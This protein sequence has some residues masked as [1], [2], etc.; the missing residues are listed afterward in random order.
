MTNSDVPLSLTLPYRNPPIY[1][2]STF[3]QFF[4]P[5]LGFTWQLSSSL[6]TKHGC[7]AIGPSVI[8]SGDRAARRA[9]PQ[10][11]MQE[12]TQSTKADCAVCSLASEKERERVRERNQNRGCL[13]FFT[14][15]QPTETTYMLQLI[16][17]IQEVRTNTHTLIHSHKWNLLRACRMS[18]CHLNLLRRKNICPFIC[19]VFTFL[20]WGKYIYLYVVVVH[21]WREREFD[22]GLDIIAGGRQLAD[23][24]KYLSGLKWALRGEKPAPETNIWKKT[25]PCWTTLNVNPHKFCSR[26]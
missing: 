1:I 23:T 26:L 19:L 16:E 21:W 15:V 20:T 8:G 7:W 5:L 17:S 18:L 22:G 6:S 2:P 14:R 9:L 24:T 25:C 3:L 4:F 13:S 11:D 10:P 12:K